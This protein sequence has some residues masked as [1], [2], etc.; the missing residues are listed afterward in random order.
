M[1]CVICQSR[2]RQCRIFFSVRPCRTCVNTRMHRSCYRRWK[3]ESDRKCPNCRAQLLTLPIAIVAPT[4]I[5]PVSITT[6]PSRIEQSSRA[7][8]TL[9]VAWAREL[10]SEGS[11][12]HVTITIRDGA[13]ATFRIYPERSAFNELIDICQN[14]V[15][16]LIALSIAFLLYILLGFIIQGFSVVLFD[17]KFTTNIFTKQH[18]SASLIGLI[19]SCSIAICIANKERIL[20]WCHGSNR[21]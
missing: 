17:I 6:A 20:R 5:T 9:R 16:N 14:L 10:C 18:F 12:E 13:E 3:R 7:Q 19:F 2:I 15:Y 1:I 21:R 11:M 4:P 8:A